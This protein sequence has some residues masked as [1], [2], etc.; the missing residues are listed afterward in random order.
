MNADE[1]AARARDLFLDESHPY[2]CAE[3]TFMVLKE[4]F[5]LPDPTDPAAAMAL[6]G[7][8]ANGGGICGAITGAALVAGLLAAGRFEDHSRAKHAAREA[9]AAVMDD[10]RERFGAVDCRTLVGVEIRT[11]KQHQAF[12]DSGTWR[13]TCMS[14]FEFVVRAL[15]SLPAEESWA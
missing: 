15:A 11:P 1:A 2:G 3:T 13:E 8:V 4:V 12:I 5:E 7:G 6:N 9:I 14:Q 10:F